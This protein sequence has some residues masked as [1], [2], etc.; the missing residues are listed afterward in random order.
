MKFYEYTFQH[1]IKINVFRDLKSESKI[2]RVH[3][4][5]RYTIFILV[6]HITTKIKHKNYSQASVV[7]VTYVRVF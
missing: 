6:I 2:D 1:L 7:H 5:H 4:I 3:N